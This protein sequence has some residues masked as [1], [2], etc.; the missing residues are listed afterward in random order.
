MIKKKKTKPQSPN[1]T[2]STPSPTQVPTFSGLSGTETGSPWGIPSAWRTRT[3][4]PL[5][6]A[7][8]SVL[9]QPKYYLAQASSWGLPRLPM[10]PAPLG[11]HLQEAQHVPT[12]ADPQH[13]LPYASAQE[14]DSVLPTHPNYL[15]SAGW[16]ACYLSRAPP[17]PKAPTASSRQPFGSLR[18]HREGT[19]GQGP[20]HWLLFKLK[21]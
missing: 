21:K 6:Q 12:L 1:R 13:H 19:G 3:N 2:P 16:L 9:A 7:S 18:C 20:G 5:P 17:R 15:C 14:P 10:G 11:L 4:F 8:H